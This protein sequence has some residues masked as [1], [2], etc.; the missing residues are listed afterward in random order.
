MVRTKWEL[1]KAA[2]GLWKGLGG[3]SKS[4]SA[5]RKAS[6]N[7]GWM[8]HPGPRMPPG[9]SSCL[10]APCTW[11]PS[12]ARRISFL[13]VAANGPQVGLPQPTEL[14]VQNPQGSNSSVRSLPAPRSIGGQ[15]GTRNCPRK[16]EGLA[17]KPREVCYL[18]PSLGDRL[19]PAFGSHK[20]NVCH[21]EIISCAGLSELK[22]DVGAIWLTPS[23]EGCCSAGASRQQGPGTQWELFCRPGRRPCT[24]RAGGPFLPVWP[25]LPEPA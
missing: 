3:V 11:F 12:L 20:A 8:R 1:A 16:G 14:Q 22:S 18:P 25:A 17:G 4:H 2:R 15:L 21:L 6:T 5:P 19:F 9:P 24:W 7:Q 23:H 13:H 10:P